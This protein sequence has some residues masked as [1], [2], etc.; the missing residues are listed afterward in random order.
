[1]RKQA[2]SIW[3]TRS[4]PYNL[5]TAQRLRAM[6]LHVITVPLLEV[7][8]LPCE[9]ALTRPDL[10]AFTSVH[11]VRHHPYQSD[12]TNTPVLAVGDTTAAAARRSG[13][14]PIRCARRTACC[15]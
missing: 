12:W 2:P 5:L 6:G 9:T 13:A 3:V 1:M 10:L 11:G 4:S 15:S 8:Q 7:R 14:S